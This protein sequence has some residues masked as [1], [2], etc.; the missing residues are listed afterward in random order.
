MRI[1]RLHLC[2]V[3]VSVC[4]CL[5]VAATGPATAAGQ[6]TLL[7][8]DDFVYKGA[9]R[10]PADN[11]GWTY[12]GG[13]LAYYPQGD[14]G[15]GADGYPG[16][17]FGIGNDQRSQVTEVSI[18]EPV[19]SAAKR[20]DD[21]NTAKTIQPFSPV[22]E[23][24]FT[25][26]DDGLP[27]RA[28]IAYLPA[29][30]GQRSGMLYLTWGEHYQ[31]EQVPSH[32]MCGLDL[33]DPQVKGPWYLADFENFATNDYLFAIPESWEAQNAPGLLLAT[34]RFRDGSLGGSGPSLFAF[35]PVDKGSPPAKN[36]RLTSVKALLLYGKGYEPEGKDRVMRGYTSAD[37]WTG[38]EWMTAGSRSSVIFAGTKGRGNFWYGFSNGVVWPD[39]PPYPD[40]PPPPHNDRGWWA[41]SFEGVIV[42]FDP[43]DLAKVA[44]GTLAPYEPQ[45]YAELKLD[46]HLWHIASPVQKM[47]LGDIAFD[48]GRGFLY[49]A[50]P[51]AD[52]D[53]PIIHV[54][55]IRDSN[56][57]TVSSSPSIKATATRVSAPA[58][59]V[60]ESPQAPGCGMVTA[61]LGFAA[62]SLI[63]KRFRS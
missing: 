62:C 5:A 25:P 11:D 26:A 54:F 56:I 57:G 7:Q 17:L 61:V 49:V 45:P 16:S 30:A 18:P 39:N 13:G 19:I 6:D 58:G 14:T 35:S 22:F 40:Y 29:Q 43:D 42:F 21:L 53:R 33:A 48:P 37:E 20:L 8:P 41:E 24:I 1:L 60:P 27:Q 15:G 32:A 59:Y 23:G 9:F 52:G 34:G 51:F 3:V 46:P 44:A 4:L 2:R 50:E 38:G 55:S 12:G 63:I 28:D 31:Y 10:L 47:H 36:S